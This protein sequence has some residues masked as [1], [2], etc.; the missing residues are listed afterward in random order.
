MRRVTV[1]GATGTI[2]RR[3]VAA[4]LARGDGVVALSRDPAR[5]ATVLGRDGVEVNGWPDPTAAPPPTDALSGA[6]AV[7]HLLGEPVAQRWTAEAKLRI[8]D[9][10]VQSTRRLV[11]ALHELPDDQRPDVLVSQSAVGIYGASDDRELDEQGPA[12]TDFL[13][14]VVTEWEHE[15]QAAEPAMRV[16]RT[17]TGVVLTASGG[18]LAR[19]LPFF[20]LGIGGPVAGGRQY[21]PWIHLDDTVAAMLF[22]LDQEA[23]SGAVNLTAPTPVTNVEFSRALGRALHRP[24]VLPV[25]GP[26]LRLLYGEMGEI[27]TT[28]QRALPRRLLDLGFRFRYPVVDQALRD[29]LEHAGP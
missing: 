20:R 19:M 15:A 24:A 5:A 29:A 3:V 16:V 6:D 2:G 25:P 21:V 22:C 10:R 28:G 23:A 13:A 17:R 18:A 8:R 7:V 11:A 27:V 12:A 1:T 14:G 4:L 26:A 9:S